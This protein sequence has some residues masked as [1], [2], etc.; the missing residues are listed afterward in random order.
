MFEARLRSGQPVHT[1]RTPVEKVRVRNIGQKWR[2]KKEKSPEL[3]EVYYF[4]ILD[5]WPT[6]IS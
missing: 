1:T 2:N 3:K 5:R 4:C 6:R